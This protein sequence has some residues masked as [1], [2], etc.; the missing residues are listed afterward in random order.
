MSDRLGLTTISRFEYLDESKGKGN[1]VFS[2][3]SSVYSQRLRTG[4]CELWTDD[5]QLL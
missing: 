2:L 1:S 3:Q 5:C 4:D